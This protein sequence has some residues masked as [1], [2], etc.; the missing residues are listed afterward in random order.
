MSLTHDT[1]TRGV[2]R[3]AARLAFPTWETS[4]VQMRA[5]RPALACELMVRVDLN[6]HD[7]ELFPEKTFLINEEDEGN[8]AGNPAGK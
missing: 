6:L 7:G 5:I 1:N 2:S 3:L 8:A 4:R